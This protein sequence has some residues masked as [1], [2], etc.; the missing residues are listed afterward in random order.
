MVGKGKVRTVIV[1]RGT[2]A[3]GL[4]HRGRRRGLATR[5]RGEAEQAIEL[6]ID[7]GGQGEGI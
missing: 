3:P 7:G 4:P 6:V 2:G 1:P 5:C